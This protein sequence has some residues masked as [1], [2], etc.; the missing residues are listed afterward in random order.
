MKTRILINLMRSL[1]TIKENLKIVVKSLILTILI[2]LSYNYLLIFKFRASF[3]ILFHL[4]SV[5]D[6]HFKLFQHLLK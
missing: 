4:Q 2:N 3:S 6:F 5:F 1:K